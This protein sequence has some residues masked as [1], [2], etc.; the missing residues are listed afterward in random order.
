MEPG[1]ED[2]EEHAL[3]KEHALANGQSQEALRLDRVAAL[4]DFRVNGA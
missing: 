3:A 4:A 2:A 1:P